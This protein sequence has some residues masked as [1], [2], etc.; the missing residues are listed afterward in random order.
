MNYVFFDLESQNLFDDVGGRGNIDKLKV[1]CGITYS[2]EK[3]DFTVYWEKD[4]PALIAELKSATKVV[5]FN[6]LG[7][8][9]LVLKPYSPETRFASIPTLDMLLE[10][11][12]TLGFRI[13]L[14]S[15]A[16]ATLGTTK[17]ADGVQSVQWYRD[18][19]LDKVAEYCKAD[20]DIT[21]RVFEFGRDNGHI[22]YKSRL[23]S[24]LK[25]EVKWK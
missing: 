12:K 19:D 4:V 8:D 25:V 2:T 14:D 7:F 17:T 16:S 10:L 13:G 18:G 21:R 5:G 22:F 24:K 1:A 15:I 23:G 3:N 20:V 11:Q 6:L 9:Y